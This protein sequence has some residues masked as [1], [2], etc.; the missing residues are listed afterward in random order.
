MALKNF[1]HVALSTA[2]MEKVFAFYRDLLGLEVTV[3]VELD[4]SEPNPENFPGAE[5]HATAVWMKRT[6]ARFVNMQVPGGTANIEVFQYLTPAGKN[7]EGQ[8]LRQYDRRISH[9]G[10]QVD[11][12][13]AMVEKLQNAGVEFHWSPAADV[14]MGTLAT[15]L[16]DF[17]GNTVELIQQPELSGLG[18]NQNQ[19]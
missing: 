8:Q 1:H 3:D 2:D 11:D 5:M 19:A 10:F 18:L 13:H 7:V 12:I 14:G 17:E 15:Y 9:F 16:Y 4:F 6:R